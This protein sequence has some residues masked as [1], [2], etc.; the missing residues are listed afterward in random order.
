MEIY[1]VAYR[2]DFSKE[3]V[4]AFLENYFPVM[5]D[6]EGTSAQYEFDALEELIDDGEVELTEKDKR[7]MKELEKADVDYIE[8]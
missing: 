7:I 6:P 2:P 8:F 3:V 1:K 4:E 5:V